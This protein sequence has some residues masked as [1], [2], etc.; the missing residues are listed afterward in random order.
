MSRVFLIAATALVAVA[1]TSVIATAKGGPRGAGLERMFEQ[2]DTNQDG[3]IT[4]AEIEAANAARFAEV[5]A[6]G[7]GVLTVEEMVAHATV[8][9]SDRLTRRIEARIDRLDANSDGAL[10]LEEMA[11]GSKRLDRMF[12]RIDANSDGAITKAEAEEARGRWM[13]RNGKSE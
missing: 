7:D 6:N 1:S 4:Q 2:F 10:S 8:R 11:D 13:D 9:D 5:D 3:T 12:D